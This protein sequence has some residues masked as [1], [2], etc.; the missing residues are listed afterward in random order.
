M[1]PDM[2]SHTLYPASLHLIAA[3]LTTS[4][5]VR[6]LSLITA[7]ASFTII[8]ITLGAL[9]PTAHI[10]TRLGRKKRLTACERQGLVHHLNEWNNALLKVS[11]PCGISWAASLG[12]LLGVVGGW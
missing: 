1:V 3:Y 6:T 12:A 8:P 9:V 5:L 10:L 7:F 2:L 4:K 11:F